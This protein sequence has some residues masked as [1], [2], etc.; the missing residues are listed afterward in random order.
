MLWYCWRC[1]TPLSNTETKMDDVYRDRQDPAVTVGLRLQSHRARARRRV[2][3][4]SGRRRRGR[5]RRTSPSPCTRTSSYVAGARRPTRHPAS[6]I[7]L[8]EARVGAYARELGDEPPRAA[9][10]SPARELSARATSPPFD[11]FAGR[12]ATRTRCWPPTTSP[13]T[14]APGIVHIAPAFGEEDKVVTDAAGIEAVVPVEH[15]RRVRRARCRPY[16]GHARVRGEQRDHPRPARRA[17]GAAAA[18]RDLRPPV[19]ALLALRQP[20]HPARRRARGSSQVTQFRDR[21]V[22]LN[23]QI[24]LGARAHPRR[25]VRQVAG[26]RARLVDLAQPVLGLADPGVGLATTRAYPRIG[27]LRLAGRAGARLRRAADRPAP[28]VHRRADPPEPG[29]PDRAAR[30]CAGCRRCSTAGSSRARCRSRRCTTR[31]RTRTGSST[32]T[33]AT[34]SSSTTARRAAGSTR[35]T[36]WPRRCSTGRR[37]A[38]CVAHGIVLGDDGAED[39]ASRGRTTRT[40]TRSST[41]TAPTPCAGSSWRVPILRGGDLIVT[42]QGIREGVRQAVLPL[43]NTWYFLSLYANAAGRD[44]AVAHRLAAR[45]RPLRAREDARRWSTDVDRGAWT[46]HDIAGACE[47]VR[48][49]ARGADQLVRPPLARAVLGRRRATR[50]TRCTP[51]WRSRAGSPRRCCR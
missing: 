27:R 30:R 13:P 45:A 2:T 5:C 19:P 6:G 29:R 10:G 8:A 12:R 41:A 15:P 46:V 25:P 11:F 33:R 9:R 18:P 42:E 14:T 1:E 36:C 51:C 38:T 47:Q 23:Q 37:S 32:T 39:V 34:S 28:P 21:M 26:E 48:D 17:S 44:G 43:W 35:C 3:R 24:T 22:E 31:S 40:S 4:S 16:A 49:H 20:A 7:V 50:S